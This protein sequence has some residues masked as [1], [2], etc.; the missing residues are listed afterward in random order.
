MSEYLGLI[1]PY[2]VGSWN[3]TGL[4]AVREA[5][6]D[7]AGQRSL[8]LAHQEIRGGLLPGGVPVVVNGEGLGRCSAL[9]L[10]DTVTRIDTI[11]DLAG[12]DRRRVAAYMERTSA[13][14][15]PNP[16]RAVFVYGG[17]G[18]RHEDLEE[19]FRR[20]FWGPIDVR[21]INFDSQQAWS[22]AFNRSSGRLAVARTYPNLQ[23]S[24][25][26]VFEPRDER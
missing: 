20:E 6:V 9:I 2:E 7:H 15:V 24:R 14:S 3:G 4:S 8:T 1:Q 12:G 13:V 17:P 19:L 25:Y 21:G 26:Q 10:R 22:F 23:L 18:S 16:S 5:V 11:A